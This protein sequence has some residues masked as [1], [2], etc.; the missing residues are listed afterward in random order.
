[1]MR[2]VQATFDDQNHCG[3]ETNSR[4][5]LWLDPGGTTTTVAKKYIPKRHNNDGFM[6]N[7]L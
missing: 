7:T 5:H 2:Q 6:V 4:Y 3:S 1:M